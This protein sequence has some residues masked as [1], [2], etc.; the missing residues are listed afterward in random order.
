MSN[1]LNITTPERFKEEMQKIKTEIGG[2]EEAAHAKMDRLMS[3]VLVELGYYDGVK[4][5]EEQDKWYA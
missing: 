5:F 4:I 2:D 1:T 3:R